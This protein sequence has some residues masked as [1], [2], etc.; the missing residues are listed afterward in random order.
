MSTPNNN[1]ILR[2]YAA[3][4]NN[5]EYKGNW[6]V[7]DSKFPEL[8]DYDKYLRQKVQPTSTTKPTQSNFSLNGVKSR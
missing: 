8:K 3:T 1:N 7:I 5:P 4:A 6:E 2:E